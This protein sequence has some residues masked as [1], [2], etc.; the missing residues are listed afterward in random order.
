MVE[1]SCSLEKYLFGLCLEPIRA[2]KENPIGCS[3][4]Y[5]H[6]KTWYF[7]VPGPMV[8]MPPTLHSVMSPT[9][10]GVDQAAMQTTRPLE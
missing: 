8:S 3:R 4:S 9:L 5:K 2:K 1:T 6:I 7:Q 10:T